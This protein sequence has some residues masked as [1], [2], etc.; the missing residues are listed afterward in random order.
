MQEIDYPYNDSFGRCNYDPTKGKV[1]VDEGFQMISYNPLQLKAA[2]V[3]GPVGIAIEAD[4]EFF[5]NYK[6]GIINSRNC[7]QDVGHAVLAV[8][9]GRDNVTGEDFILIKNSWGP[10]WGD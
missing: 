4:K 10:D 2:I 3:K 7:G 1:T 8:G 5:R 6:T 9:Y